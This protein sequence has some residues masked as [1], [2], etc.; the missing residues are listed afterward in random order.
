MDTVATERFF[1]LSQ[2][3][4]Q[5]LFAPQE[6]VWQALTR[7][8]S[9]FADMKPTPAHPVFAGRPLAEHLVIHGGRIMEGGCLEIEFP[10]SGSPLVRDCGRTLDGAVVI[11]AGAV[12]MGRDIHFGPG[13]VVESGAML[14]GPLWIG[15]RTEVRQG[16][17]LR[18]YCVVGNDCVVGHCT[19]MKHAIMLD[20]AKA[21]HFNYIG[22][23]ILGHQVNLGAGTKLANLRFTSGP[24]RIRTPEGELNTGLHKLGAI[25]GDWVQTGCNAV[26]NPGAILGPHSLV[27][28]NATA[29]NGLHPGRS[30]LR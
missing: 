21:G 25:L 13:T 29:A 7:L 3:Q 23:S 18:G 30:I 11:M 10:P 4:W 5:D 12:C 28:P 27:L 1:D 15:A 6:P 22:D 14:K 2:V 16:A 17:Y 26:T 9:F 8:K 20:H 19:E 24:V